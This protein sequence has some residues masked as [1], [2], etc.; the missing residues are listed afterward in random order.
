MGCEPYLCRVSHVLLDISTVLHVLVKRI[1]SI[2]RPVGLDSANAAIRAY[3][4]SEA[5]TSNDFTQTI[6]VRAIW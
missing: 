3:I 1:T 4:A 5:T 6:D 2:A